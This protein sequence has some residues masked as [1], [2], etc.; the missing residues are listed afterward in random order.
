MLAA[1]NRHEALSKLSIFS[2][3][4][5]T[6]VNVVADRANGKSVPADL[7]ETVHTLVW[8]APLS[9]VDELESIR[10]QL[11]LRYGKAELQAAALN[12]AGAACV[13]A[14]VAVRLGA[15]GTVPPDAI[16]LEELKKVAALEGVVFGAAE[17]QEMTV[18]LQVP[19]AAAA[20]EVAVAGPTAQDEPGQ[21]RH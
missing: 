1:R 20:A 10:E 7:L 14:F 8:A 9:N 4:L 21:P 12:T 6:R 13:N 15:Q 11:A 17:L 19:A 18:G 5:N 2:E 3:H 16:V